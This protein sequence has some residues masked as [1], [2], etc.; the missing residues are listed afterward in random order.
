MNDLLA[1][2]SKTQELHL[3]S[4]QWRLGEFALANESV[5][6]LWPEVERALRADPSIVDQLQA[7][8]FFDE[9]SYESA[10]FLALFPKLEQLVL[11]GTTLLHDLSA[12]AGHPSL[13][14][15][16]FTNY[17]GIDP[18][19][20]GL[21]W[22]D[23]L[24]QLEE[25]V[26]FEG[27]IE[28]DGWAPSEVMLS[29]LRSLWINWGDLE[30]IRHEA[31]GRIESLTLYLSADDID[32]LIDLASDD[33]ERPQAETAVRTRLLALGRTPGLKLRTCLDKVESEEL[34]LQL[35]DVIGRCLPAGVQV[36]RYWR[37]QVMPLIN[38]GYGFMKRG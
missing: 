18:R 34:R 7:V 3:E 15:V 21:R 23:E 14:R 26:F 5:D 17:C 2:L 1:A 27:Y 8:T 16:A 22:L 38:N 28:L 25:L 35:D 6:E 12:L 20:G 37:G 36:E 4:G 11:Y 10:P 29:R 19:N 33:N 24:P 9:G 30:K 13:R 31:L 32:E